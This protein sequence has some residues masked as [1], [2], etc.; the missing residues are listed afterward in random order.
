MV[1]LGLLVATPAAGASSSF[2]ERIEV[3]PITKGGEVVG[4]RLHLTLRPEG[5][6]RRVR[7]GLGSGEKVRSLTARHAMEPR[8]GYLAHQFPE[9]ALE[10][11]TPRKVT[12]ELLYKDAPHLVPGQTLELV[13]AWRR[14]D[15]NIHVW[16]MKRHGV[17]GTFVQLPAP[18]GRGAGRLS[19]GASVTQAARSGRPA[20]AARKAQRR[21]QAR[22]RR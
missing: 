19:A 22:A 15:R 6:E 2:H 9:V 12:F 5:G 18:K 11:R 1:L 7:V 20:A 21:G 13:T 10:G 3:A 16:G 14:A 4:L 17:D 8:L